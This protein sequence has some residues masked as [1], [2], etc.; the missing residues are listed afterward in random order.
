MLEIPKWNDQFGDGSY[1][2]TSLPSTNQRRP[3]T[4]PVWLSGATRPG[5]LAAAELAVS[6]AAASDPKTFFRNGICIWTMM[7]IYVYIYID[8]Y[9]YVFVYVY[10]YVYVCIYIDVY[11]YVYVSISIC[12][13]ICIYIDVYI[14]VCIYIYVYVYVYV[15]VYIYRYIYI[16]LSCGHCSIPSQH[17]CI[18]MILDL[19]KWGDFKQICVWSQ[20]GYMGQKLMDLKPTGTPLSVIFVS[21]EPSNFSGSGYDRSNKTPN[22]T[23]NPKVTECAQFST[24]W[25]WGT[26]HFGHVLEASSN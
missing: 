17:Q 22:G 12:I 13:C 21:F 8:V 1:W 2:F 24:I 18:W 20:S 3:M 5:V 4:W 19:K 11:V 14:Y 25:S 7:E 10:V 6:G 23:R 15:Y 16:P 26:I 9:V